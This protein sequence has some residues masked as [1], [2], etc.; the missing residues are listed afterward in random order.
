MPRVVE[1]L[2]AS[3]AAEPGQLTFVAGD[4]IQ[5]ITAGEPDGWWEGSLRGTKGWFPSSFCSAP[6]SDGIDAPG[7]HAPAQMRAVALYAYQ[8]ATPDELSLQPG[9]VILITDAEQSWWTGELRGQTGCFPANFVEMMRD[10]GGSKGAPNAAGMMDLSKALGAAVAK[11]RAASEP[12]PP[13]A[14]GASNVTDSSIGS[15]AAA[16]V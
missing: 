13:P 8:A 12:P 3:P 9:D 5:V 2:F 6:F 11:G 1:A 16:T 14:A 7:D 10:D 15:L 4:V